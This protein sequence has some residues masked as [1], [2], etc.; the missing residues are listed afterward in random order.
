MLLLLV[1]LFV[2]GV[3]DQQSKVV[4]FPITH[5]RELQVE[6]FGWFNCYIEAGRLQNWFD[7]LVRLCVFA[8]ITIVLELSPLISSVVENPTT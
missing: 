6:W 5:G 4:G 3:P 7:G 2:A 1:C 8:S